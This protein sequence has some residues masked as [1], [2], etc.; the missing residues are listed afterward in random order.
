[1]RPNQ[2]EVTYVNHVD[3]IEGR[4]TAGML[5]RLLVGWKL[6]TSDGWLSGAESR[7]LS[8]TFVMPEQRGRLYVEAHPAVRKDDRTEIIRLTLTARGA[9]R[10]AGL[11]DVR[12]WLDLGRERVV[13]GFTSLT[14]AE[15]HKIWRRRA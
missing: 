15:M 6:E 14:T 11:Q 7:G 12:E 9:P 3:L 10:A 4:T 2:C 8:A 5:D 13:R 1:M